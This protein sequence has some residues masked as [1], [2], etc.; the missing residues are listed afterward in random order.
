MWG[1]VGIGPLGCIFDQQHK[2]IYWPFNPD[3]GI[4]ERNTGD[5]PVEYLST[6]MGGTGKFPLPD[7]RLMW[8][9]RGGTRISR[10]N[11]SRKLWLRNGKPSGAIVFWPIEGAGMN[12]V[13]DLTIPVECPYDT[14]H[15]Q[16]LDQEYP[17]SVILE[18]FSKFGPI[19]AANRNQQLYN[20]DRKFMYI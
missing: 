13:E 3:L 19:V 18:F 9:Q 4:V 2:E 15:V 6:A 12:M 7:P 14:I 10:N 16:G 5:V 8:I 11:H 20:P 1:N 17:T